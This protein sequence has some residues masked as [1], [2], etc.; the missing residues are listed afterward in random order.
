LENQGEG[1]RRSLPCRR[2]NDVRG[3]RA[4]RGRRRKA[5]GNYMRYPREAGI[6]ITYLLETG[7]TRRGEKRCRVRPQ[8]LGVTPRF[9]LTPGP[10]H[11]VFQYLN[12]FL[13]LRAVFASKAPGRPLLPARLPLSR[14]VLH[15]E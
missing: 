5:R 6:S 11:E 13:S 3:S 10:F 1:D 9:I 15:A 4:K 7:I 14:D 2:R 8:L 12:P